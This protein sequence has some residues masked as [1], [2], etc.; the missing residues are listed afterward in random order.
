MNRKTL[1]A[2]LCGVALPLVLMGLGSRTGTEGPA[3]ESESDGLTPARQ[4]SW[5]SETRIVVLTESGN[6]RQMNL[7]E[8]LTG[9]VLAEM[10]ADF[11]EEALRAQAVVA[12]TYTCKR[13][14]HNKH[15]AAAVCT[16]S[17]C[18]QGFR[19]PE[20]YVNSGESQESVE[21][22]RSAVTETDGQV[23]VYGGELIDATYFSCSGGQTEDAVAVW[24]QDVPYLQSVESP[25]EEDAP[26]YSSRVSYTPENFKLLTGVSGAGSVGSWFGPVTHTDGGGVDTIRICGKTF[27]G[28]ELRSILG[29]RSTMFTVSVA[30]GMIVFETKGFGHRVGMSQYGAQAMAEEGSSYREILE[31]YYVGALLTDQNG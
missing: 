3:P 12:R 11:G 6:L 28:T 25:G 27:T 10:P 4:T 18:C 24:G 26:R 21:K 17:G 9:V 2:F 8:Y 22:I 31:H 23:L 14:E 1:I 7:G 30:E 20:D 29:L 13:M 5:D 15:D 16:N 19:N